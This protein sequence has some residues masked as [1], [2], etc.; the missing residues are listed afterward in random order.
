MQRCRVLMVAEKPSIAQVLSSALCENGTIDKRRG[1]SPSSPVYE[2]DGTFHGRPA[3]FVVT[4]TTGH[5]YSLDFSQECNN[6]DKVS[7]GELF[8]AATVRCYD[9]RARIPEH[10]QKEAQGCHA[11]VLWLDCDRE[12]ENICF[13]VIGECLPNMAQG[14]EWPGAYANCI[15]RAQFSSLASV[16][17]QQAMQTLGHPDIRQAHSVDARQEIDLRLGV[18][19][20]RLQTLYFRKHF[21]AQLGRK[22]VTYGPCQFPTLWFCVKRHCEI[23]AHVPVPFW[24]LQIDV[25]LCGATFT[26][27]RT[28][29]E[30][31]DSREVQ[32]KAAALRGTD[33]C[34]IRSVR[35]YRSKINRPLPLNTV[36]LLKMASDELGLGP[37]DAMHCAEQLYLKGIMSYPRTETDK[38]PGNFDL[39]GTVQIMANPSA[40]WARHATQI[41]QQGL[42]P[43]RQ[44]G[45]DA[46]DH[47][48]ITPVKFTSSTSQ[49]GGEAPYALYKAICT[50]FLSTVAPDCLF[51]EAEVQLEVAG[52]TFSARSSRCVQRGWLDVDGRTASEQGPVDLQSLVGHEGQEVTVSNVNVTNHQTQ[53]PN[54]LS[55]SELLAFMDRHGIGTDA[56]MAQHVGNVQKRGY[57]DL[58]ESTRRMVPSALGLAMAHSY[59]LLDKGLVLPSVRARIENECGSVAKGEATKETVIAR[60]IRIFERKMHNFAM[61]IDRVPLMLAVAYAK[62]RGQIQVAGD[63]AQQGL[64]L[65]AE[66]EAVHQSVTLEQLL[67]DRERVALEEDADEDEMPPPQEAARRVSER[68]EAVQR[69]QQALEQLGFGSADQAAQPKAKAKSASRPQP[70]PEPQQTSSGAPPQDNGSGS[71]PIPQMLVAAIVQQ[72]QQPPSAGC[73]PLAQV[74]QLIPG[75]KETQLV[76][77]GVLDVVRDPA[78]GPL[79]VLKGVPFT[80]PPSGSHAVNHKANSNATRTNGKGY[81]KG[82]DDKGKG[83]SGGKGKQGGKNGKGGKDGKDGRDRE[84]G[85]GKFGGDHFGGKNGKNDKG[86]GGK[87]GMDRDNGKGKGKGG[88][89]RKGGKD[90]ESDGDWRQAQQWHHQQDGQPFMGQQGGMQQG[91]MQQSAPNPY[92]GNYGQGQMG[93]DNQFQHYQKDQFSQQQFPDQFSQQQFQ[94][95][96]F[97]QSF[98]QQ[99]QQQQRPQSQQFQQQPPQGFQQ[100]QQQHQHQQQV[101][102]NFPQF[103]QQH[104]P[105]ASDC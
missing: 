54:H 6:W 92:G 12:G 49:C 50:H 20:S 56:S 65:W 39:Q 61:R 23:E 86:Y 73:L 52:E 57:V 58:D 28:Q 26:C 95:Q 84:Y 88:G 3:R 29:G 105:Q 71:S 35:A 74:C 82:K 30:F 43:P 13:E 53:P 72:I 2:Y 14:M 7:P 38:Y 44:D 47:P 98:Q 100:F 101:Q 40:P 104:L 1:V 34:Q 70:P 103:Q 91:G 75:V 51:E 5:V 93:F 96:A 21:G 17:L 81:G 85:G 69:V 64:D 31:W 77:T 9:P 32:A 89:N 79:V 63:A 68:T 87:G 78:A 33:D 11:L 48:P 62:E 46:G 66:A 90:R 67:D 83:D 10:L 36:A 37:S 25:E 99:Q 4:A 27:Q 42:T 97:Q 76:E 24:R 41:L 8:H 18:A 80:P 45:Y 16:D 15:Y 94:Q 60:T 22:M 102:Q 55:E 59:A 19:F